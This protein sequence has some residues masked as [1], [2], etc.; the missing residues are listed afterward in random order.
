LI[1]AL[2]PGDALPPAMRARIADAAEGNPLYVEEFVGTLI[3][4]GALVADKD[5]W[6]ASRDLQSIA[7]P[8]TIAALLSARLDR[9][10][11]EER[12]V[13]ERASVVGRVFDQ[14][15]VLALSPAEG[16]SDVPR[17]LVGLVRKELI[18]PDRSGLA[19]GDAFRFRHMLI[20][21]AAYER[22][23]EV[24]ACRAPRTVRRLARPG[25]G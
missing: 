7:V 16:R 19:Q 22:L 15:S 24:G 14:L 25:R 9:L 18:R 11:P 5:G 2:V 13:A 12:A 4:D 23:A 6:I 8:P 3:D 17:N 21:D 10:A 20:R 1:D